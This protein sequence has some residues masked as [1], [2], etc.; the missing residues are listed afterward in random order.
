MANLLVTVYN[1]VP[2]F[3]DKAGRCLATK[4]K[5]MSFS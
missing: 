5:E 3:A 1:A 4:V 2:Q